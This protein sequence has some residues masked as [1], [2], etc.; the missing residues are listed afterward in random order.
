MITIG[1]YKIVDILLL[2]AINPINPTN[3]TLHQAHAS[4]RIII[5]SYMGNIDCCAG[6]EQQLDL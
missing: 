2:E 3:I 4:H 6:G 5:N 1:K